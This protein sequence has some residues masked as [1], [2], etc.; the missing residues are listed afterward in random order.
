M[1]SKKRDMKRLPVRMPDHQR[2]ALER[3]SDETGESMNEI[4]CR[5]VRA[6]LAEVAAERARREILEDT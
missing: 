6:H 4:V 2:E 5:L 1:T 3:L